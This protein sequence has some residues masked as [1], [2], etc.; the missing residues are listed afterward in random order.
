MIGALDQKIRLERPTVTK[1]AIGG[2]SAVWSAIPEDPEP[3]ARVKMAGGQEGS[4]PGGD[5]AMQRAVFTVRARSDLRASDRIVWGG[6]VWNITAIERP[7]ARARY[8]K[9]DATAGELSR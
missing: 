4:A 2:R 3:F 6:F 1:D 5:A 7:V 8:M 9:I